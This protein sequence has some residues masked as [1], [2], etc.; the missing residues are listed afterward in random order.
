MERLS[1]SQIG[2]ALE[3]EVIGAKDVYVDG[4]SIDTR[5]LKEG[6]LFIAI[7]GENF[8]GHN[9]LEDAFAKGAKAAI[10][11]KNK[12]F[13]S[14]NPLILVEDTKRGLQ[15]LANYYR[16]RF[17]IIVVGV[18]GSTGKTTTKDMIYSVLSQKYKTLKTEGNF[19]NE[20]GLP[21]TLLRLDSSYQA[22]VVEMGMRGLGQIRELAKIAQPD[23]GVITNVGYAHIEILKTKENIAKAKSELIESLGEEGFAILNGD[24]PLVKDMEKISKGK[25]INYGLKDYN[26]VKG[27]KLALSEDSDL[28]FEL[29]VKDLTSNFKVKLPVP[30]KYNV[31]NALAAVSVGISLN[32]DLEKIRDGLMNFE[33]TE[34]RNKVFDSKRAFKVIND[35]Y[36]ANPTSM[37][38]AL[39]TL[40]DIGEGKKF[41]VLG[42]MLELG[43]VGL[44]EH[45]R[46]GQFLLN[47]GIDYLFTYGDLAFY[48]GEGAKKAGMKE[49]CI[50][51]YQDKEELVEDL[52]KKIK[53][54][55]T[56]LV[57]GSRGMELEDVSKALEER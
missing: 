33:L 21:L 16:N 56:V 19:N 36:N 7:E 28:Q 49:S 43:D 41:A 51:S 45:R 20:I 10:V 52:L 6:D 35:T 24:D 26:K 3:G 4:V 32:I 37:R 54:G 38:A 17:D 2:L 40:I 22:L 29:G 55:D 46:L 53:E 5:T 57:K 23:I 25:V 34:L 8:D 11:A 12:A 44:G 9:F 30:G 1:L 50:Y 39:D 13:E 42:D 18:T 31:Y 15:S 27:S 48:I 14:G 47:K